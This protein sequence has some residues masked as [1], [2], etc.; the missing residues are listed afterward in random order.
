MCPRGYQRWN[1]D[2]DKLSQVV[3]NLL[4]NAIKY[5]PAGGLVAA[6]AGVDGQEVWIGVADSGPGIAAQEQQRVFEPFYRSERD[7][8]FPQGWGWD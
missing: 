1:V 7:R 5:T 6:T 8:R 2:P 3:G 4:S